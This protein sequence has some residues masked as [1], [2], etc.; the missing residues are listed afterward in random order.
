MK[1]NANSVQ[2]PLYSEIYSDERDEPYLFWHKPSVNVKLEY[3]YG[4]FVFKTNKLGQRSL[5]DEIR[6]KKSIVFI[7]DSI[8]EG[9]SVENTET[10]PYLVSKYFNIPTINLGL[11]SSNTVQEYLLGK[12]KIRPDF[13][14][15]TLVL[16]FCLNDISQNLYRR[17]FE[18][19]IG[20]WKYFDTAEVDDQLAFHTFS[21]RAVASESD[22]SY[23]HYEKGILKESEAV[24]FIYRIVKG[25]LNLQPFK[26]K[27]SAEAW[28]NTE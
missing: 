4:D 17:S 3:E 5:S 20:N 13:N 28:K 25:G 7:G 6:F 19:L 2:Y 24:L 22:S 12:Q 27:Y 21:K 16:G 15:E 1:L 8:V 18:P 9:S 26:R 11:G 14:M 10:L 23:L